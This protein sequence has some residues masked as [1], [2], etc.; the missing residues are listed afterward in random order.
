MRVLVLGHCFL[1]QGS[2]P[3]ATHC[4]GLNTGLPNLLRALPLQASRVR[5]TSK[6]VGRALAA[7]TGLRQSCCHPQVGLGRGGVLG[8]GASATHSS[9]GHP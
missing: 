5:H 9:L 7:F 8:W 4:T 2:E 6:A 1:L 3:M